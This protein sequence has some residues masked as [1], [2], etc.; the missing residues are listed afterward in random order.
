MNPLLDNA[1][2]TAFERFLT[3]TVAFTI[4]ILFFG[5]RP[6]MGG[7]IPISRTRPYLKYRELKW[8]S[9]MKKPDLLL[10]KM[11]E[12]KTN[13]NE[14]LARTKTNGWLELKR[15]VGSN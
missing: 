9:K 11:L 14:W 10:R 4:K 15:M 1:F 3:E 2:L 7:R 12:I 13:E 8:S 5:F 6:S